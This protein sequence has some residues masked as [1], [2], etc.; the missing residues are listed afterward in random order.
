M[1]FTLT[2]EDIKILCKIWF[3]GIVPKVVEQ[4][5]IKLA[6]QFCPICTERQLKF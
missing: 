3:D 6:L 5:Q 1:L 2:K 4:K